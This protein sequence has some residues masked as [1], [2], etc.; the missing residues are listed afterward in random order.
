[1]RVSMHGGPAYQGGGHSTPGWCGGEA[2]GGRR[3]QAQWGAGRQRRVERLEK[4]YGEKGGEV[5]GFL[6]R[7]SDVGGEEKG[8]R[9]S[10]VQRR[11]E[12]K[13]EEGSCS[14]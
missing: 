12:G 10:G 4:K 3:R 14:V 6:W 5:G 13:T 7:P 9:G 8:G 11:V 2:T 1:M